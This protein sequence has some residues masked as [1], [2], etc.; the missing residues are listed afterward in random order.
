MQRSSPEEDTMTDHVDDYCECGSGLEDGFNPATG[1]FD[2]EEC[3]QTIITHDACGT[4][5]YSPAEDDVCDVCHRRAERNTDAAARDEPAQAVHDRHRRAHRHA[6]R[7]QLRRRPLRG[8]SD[9]RR[10]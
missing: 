3:S 7:R 6:P 5:F 4:A 10:P 8:R 2:C 9:R 1:G